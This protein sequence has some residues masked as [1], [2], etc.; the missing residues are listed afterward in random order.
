M[1]FS[2]IP[3]H[4]ETKRWRA[5]ETWSAAC[6]RPLRWPQTSPDLKAFLATRPSP[7]KFLLLAGWLQISAVDP[8][9]VWSVLGFV[10]F[11]QAHR[12]EHGDAPQEPWKSS[13]CA[14]I[15]LRC[16]SCAWKDFQSVCEPC[17]A[18][19][20]KLVAPVRVCLPKDQMTLKTALILE[21]QCQ[22]P[23]QSSEWEA[24]LRFAGLFGQ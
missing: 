24:R 4:A 21:S 16:M 14:D 9:W 23:R 19:A 2:L 7:N 8:N 20:R 3:L 13:K 17:H 1:H 18:A 12:R 6:E 10:R 15:G 11:A 5:S 22:L